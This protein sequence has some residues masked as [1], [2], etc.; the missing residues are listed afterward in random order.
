V[1]PKPS[2]DRSK[3][4]GIRWI[5]FG[6]DK[7]YNP[8]IWLAGDHQ[9]ATP[10]DWRK[11]EEMKE[12][13]KRAIASEGPKALSQEHKEA[14]KTDLL[15]ETYGRFATKSGEIWWQNEPMI[16]K[17]D[18]D[19]GVNGCNIKGLGLRISVQLQPYHISSTWA[20]PFTG[21]NECPPEPLGGWVVD[22]TEN[23]LRE[24]EPSTKNLLCGCI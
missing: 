17:V 7:I 18:R 8:V 14:M 10:W 9:N 2:A 1:E 5:K 13:F 21:D 20:R 4:S 11:L 3:L 6:F 24:K 16:L 19:R 12:K 23:P 22:I 15:R